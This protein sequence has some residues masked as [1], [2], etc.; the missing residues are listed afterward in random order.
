MNKTLGQERANYAFN[1]VKDAKKDFN[2]EKK[3]KEYKVLVKGFPSMIV[4]NGLGQALAFLKAKGKDHHSAL[5]KNIDDWFKNPASPIT[6]NNTDIL[7]HIINSTSL[8]YRYIT[9][10]ALL[11]INWFKKFVD[12]EI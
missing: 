8:D 10:E 6:I 7:K 2:S 12:A 3:S 9:E 11:L 4:N 5:Y 1:C